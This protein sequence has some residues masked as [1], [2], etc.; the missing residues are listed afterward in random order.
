MA[1]H[2]FDRRGIKKHHSYTL[3]EAAAT[4]GASKSTLQRWVRSNDLPSIRD[5]RPIL[6]LGE[7]LLEFLNGRVG[8]KTTCPPGEC[9]CV[10]CRASRKPAGGMAEFR[11][12][13]GKSGNLR[14]LCPDC[15]NLMHR[16]TS[17]E[18]LEAI[19]GLLDVTVVELQQRINDCD[20][21]SIND[22]F[23]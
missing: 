6:I 16:R 21:A 1:G 20:E 2:R 9:Y 11:Y 8:P 3:D 17:L 12:A 22:H 13:E 23:D 4:I 10:K 19:R 15:G 14:G 18:Q 7:D 5:H